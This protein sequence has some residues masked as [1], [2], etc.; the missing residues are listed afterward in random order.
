MISSPMVAE[1]GSATASRFVQADEDDSC[2]RGRRIA[3]AAH[4]ESCPTCQEVRAARLADPGQQ[5]GE[6]GGRSRVAELERDVRADDRELRK[7]GAVGQ[8]ETF[9][10]PT[11]RAFASSAHQRTRD[12]FTN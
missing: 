9:V 1:I 3:L 8:L 2:E 4:H 7:A 11:S 12:D 6:D 10:E 5:T